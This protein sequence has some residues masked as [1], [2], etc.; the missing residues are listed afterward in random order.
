[1]SYVDGSAPWL[2]IYVLYGGVNTLIHTKTPQKH[3]K[4]VKIALN[5][6]L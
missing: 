2:S 4:R 3:T 6:R 5:M 1:M